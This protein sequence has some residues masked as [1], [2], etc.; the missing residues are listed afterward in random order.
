MSMIIPIQRASYAF[1][2]TTFKG[3][4]LCHY[5]SK[6]LSNRLWKRGGMDPER[7]VR[8]D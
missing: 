4:F 7:G 2:Y 5:P 8:K 3:A 1:I 6:S